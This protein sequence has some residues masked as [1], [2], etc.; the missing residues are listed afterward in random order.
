MLTPLSAL[1]SKQANPTELTMEKSLQFLYYAATQDDAILTYKASDMILAIHSN[2]SYLSE[3]KAQS[4]VGSHIFM[5]GND[6][7]PINNGAVLNILQVIKSVM[8][9][10]AEAE[11]AALFINTKTA[12]SMRTMLEE[13]GHPQ[14]QTPIQTNNSTAHALLTNKI[15]PKMLKAMDMQF[16]WLRC[17]EAQGQFRYYW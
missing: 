11:L 6:E 3:P 13:L 12:V 4:R 15:L 10:V 7:I 8:S 9:S 17:R 5:A 16:H 14:T 1:A 2:A